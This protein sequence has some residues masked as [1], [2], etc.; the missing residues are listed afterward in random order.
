MVTRDVEEM[1]KYRKKMNDIILRTDDKNI[2]RFFAQDNRVYDPGVLDQ[3]YKEKVSD[4]E[5]YEAVNIMINY[6]IF[7]LAS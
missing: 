3:C 5:L 6:G 2:K 1:R 4:E 7:L